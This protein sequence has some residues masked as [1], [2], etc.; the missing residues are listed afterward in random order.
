MICSPHFEFIRHKIV[1]GLLHSGR[2]RRNSQQSV[3]Y[4]F[5]PQVELSKEECYRVCRVQRELS[6]VHFHFATFEDLTAVLW[7]DRRDVYV[8]SSMHNRSVQ[9]VMK[10]AKGGRE[11]VP[12]PCPTAACIQL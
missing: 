1:T 10:R 3:S 11:K 12:I 4:V 5:Y 7:Q 6:Q 8:L 2:C 9:T